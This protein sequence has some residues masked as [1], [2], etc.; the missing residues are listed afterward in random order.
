MFDPVEMGRRLRRLRVDIRYKQTNIASEMGV[1]QTSV[2]AHEKG[3]QSP[4][5]ENLCWY[6]KKYG[7]SLDY[8]MGL[9]DEPLPLVRDAPATPEPATPLLTEE[10][11]LLLDT[12]RG[13][14]VKGRFRVIQLCLNEQDRAQDDR[15]SKGDTANVG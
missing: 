14:D 11:Q 5:S 8:I 3:L 6:A 2:S 4:S 10:E 7:V 15:A 13:A 9:V 1:S 12:F